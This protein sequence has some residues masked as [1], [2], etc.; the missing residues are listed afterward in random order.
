MRTPERGRFL[1]PSGTDSPLMP[2][3]VITPEKRVIT[4]LGDSAQIRAPRQKTVSD[5]CDNMA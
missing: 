1:S 2:Q 3:I 5:R 4:N